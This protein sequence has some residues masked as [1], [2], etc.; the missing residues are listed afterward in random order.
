MVYMDGMHGMHGMYGLHGMYGVYIYIY[1][2]HYT[3]VQSNGVQQ[4]VV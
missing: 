4:D 1:T 3:V 2:C